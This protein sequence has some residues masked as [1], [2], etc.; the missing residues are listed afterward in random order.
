M[1]DI[2][3]KNAGEFPVMID[4]EGEVSVGSY[5]IGR[6]QGF[7]FQV[8]PAARHSD[9]KMLLATA[10][11]RLGGEYEKRAGALVADTDHHFSPPPDPG[12]SVP[13]LWRGPRGGGRGDAE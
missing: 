11:R 7:D 13:I 5:A 10:E 12:A 8:D 6:L 4:E 1:R 2:G 3:G 9:R